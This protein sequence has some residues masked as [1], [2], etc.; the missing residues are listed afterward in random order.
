MECFH[1]VT[2]KHQFVPV[3]VSSFNSFSRK[4]VKL[5]DHQPEDSNLVTKICDGGCGIWGGFVGSL[6][7]G[8]TV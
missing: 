7:S 6:I 3:G 5:S 4:V 1:V 2:A 8:D